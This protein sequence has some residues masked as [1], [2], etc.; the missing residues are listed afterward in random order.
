MRTVAPGPSH[1]NLVEVDRQRSGG[2]LERAVRCCRAPRSATSS[3]SSSAIWRPRRPTRS[4]VARPRR[5]RPDEGQRE[6]PARVEVV[7]LGHDLHRVRRQTR[8]PRAPTTA[9][10][11]AS[12]S[13]ESRSACPRQRGLGLV[14]RRHLVAGEDPGGPRR[15]PRG[16]GCEHRRAGLPARP[17][18]RG[19]RRAAPT[20]A[21]RG[22]R[23]APTSPGRTTAQKWAGRGSAGTATLAARPS[24][25]SRPRWCHGRTRLRRHHRA[26]G[27]AGPCRGRTTTSSSCRSTL[28]ST[29]RLERTRRSSP[30]TVISVPPYFE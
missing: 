25:R 21:A 17:P 30:S 8:C 23:P 14:G 10:G 26:R 5:E 15:P 6:R 20:S 22:A 7:E 3:A 4:S 13:T 24:D 29:S 16:R 12:A 27:P 18:R 9:P 1:R 28:A 11:R 19:E 2:G